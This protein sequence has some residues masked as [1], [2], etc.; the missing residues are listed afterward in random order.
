[1]KKARRTEATAPAAEA[2][3]VVTSLHVKDRLFLREIPD[4]AGSKR[5]LSNSK[6]WRRLSPL[7]AVYAKGQLAGGAPTHDA[8][9]RF[10]AGKRYGGIFAVA[11]S[12]GRD[13]SQMIAISRSGGGMT[14]GQSQREALRLLAAIETRLGER[15]RR[16]IRMVCGEGFWP[17][18]AVRAVCG[19]YKHTIAA[20]FRE[21]LDALIEAG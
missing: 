20:R 5:V 7:E 19:D 18:E 6:A 11:Q 15:D 13:S 17:S 1:M 14:M 2:P 10:A 9:A 12:S 3:A 16:I 4:G 21:A 8:G